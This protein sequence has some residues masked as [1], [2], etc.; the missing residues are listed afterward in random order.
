MSNNKQVHDSGHMVPMDQPK[1]ALEMLRR[2]TR[3]T[4]SEAAAEPEKMF[5]QMWFTSEYDP[6]WGDQY[7]ILG[8][9]WFLNELVNISP[10]PLKLYW[11][12]NSF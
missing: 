1:A 5:A 11:G 9:P 3:G 6:K 12:A 4:L 2:W 8:F 7:R 10:K